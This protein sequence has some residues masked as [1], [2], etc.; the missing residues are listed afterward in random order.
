[1]LNEQTPVHFKE[2]S[3]ST[4]E[5]K[6]CQEI[7][8]KIFAAERAH[9]SFVQSENTVSRRDILKIARRLNAGV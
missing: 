6:I 3:V 2:H 9:H 4:L 1:M 7:I 5:M 8:C